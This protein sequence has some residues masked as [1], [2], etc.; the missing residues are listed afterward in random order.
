MSLAALIVIA[1]GFCFVLGLPPVRRLMRPL[2]GPKAEAAG[3]A[4]LVEVEHDVLGDR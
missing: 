2:A 1:S 4:S 3:P